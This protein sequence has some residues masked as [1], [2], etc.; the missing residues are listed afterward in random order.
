MDSLTM[1]GAGILPH[2]AD[3]EFQCGAL[4]SGNT[5]FGDGPAQAVELSM[6]ALPT[7]GVECW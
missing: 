2:M 5:E 7:V 6:V 3:I 4:R 1:L